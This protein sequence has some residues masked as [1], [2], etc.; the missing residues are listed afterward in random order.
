MQ[1]LLFYRSLAYVGKSNTQG[2]S[3]VVLNPVQAVFETLRGK[4]DG[5]DT[6][7][8]LPG[9][10]D[11]RIIFFV[12]FLFKICALKGAFLYVYYTHYASLFDR[13][14]SL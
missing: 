11:E 6:N 4:T 14:V 1:D 9:C 7:L 2:S 8:V 10:G 3:L 5:H 13:P 12:A